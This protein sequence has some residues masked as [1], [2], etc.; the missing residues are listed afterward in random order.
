M[1]RK[2]ESYSKLI[3]SQLT[4][5]MQRTIGTGHKMS[6]DLNT[7]DIFQGLSPQF[8]MTVGQAMEL[9]VFGKLVGFHVIFCGSPLIPSLFVATVASVALPPA[10]AHRHPAPLPPSSPSSIIKSQADKKNAV[11]HHPLHEPR[12]ANT[13]GRESP[14]HFRGRS[15]WS[16]LARC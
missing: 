11:C 9:R 4:I 10:V 7:L 12:D 13:Q 6:Y 5:G 2:R 16:A 15:A 8:I 14:S 1:S 3:T